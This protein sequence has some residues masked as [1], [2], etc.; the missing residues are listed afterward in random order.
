MQ[1]RSKLI[2]VC[3][4]DWN[5]EV[6]EVS[7]VQMYASVAMLKKEKACWKEC[8]IVEL[9]VTE[10]KWIVKENFE[11]IVKKIDNKQK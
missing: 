11:Q 1:K 8:G 3:G 9:K 10:S 5:H 4:T 7:D 6:G 2:Y